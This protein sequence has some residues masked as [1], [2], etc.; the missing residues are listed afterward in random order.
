MSRHVTWYEA[1]ELVLWRFIL[2]TCAAGAGMAYSQD[3]MGLTI[4]FLVDSVVA[5]A[6]AKQ[7]A[8]DLQGRD[9]W[10]NDK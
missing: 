2:V 1:F 6:F 9:G 8:D 10:E 5:A 3:M 7:I 4:A